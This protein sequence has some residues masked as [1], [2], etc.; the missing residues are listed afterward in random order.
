M[1]HPHSSFY[2]ALERFTR[3][4]IYVN[5]L[6]DVTVPYRTGGI[7][8]I[9]TFDESRLERGE[10]QVQVDPDYPVMIS[11]FKH[12][13]PS[14]PPKLWE[15]V[16]SKF[17]SDKLP[18]F[19]SP[20]RL[21]LRFPLNYL[22][23]LFLPILFPTFLVLVL[24]RFRGDGRNSRRRILMLDE[25]WKL[26]DGE[27][28]E[29]EVPQAKSKRD[30]SKEKQRIERMLK[31]MQK[32]AEVAGEDNVKSEHPAPAPTAITPTSSSHSKSN[33]TLNHLKSNVNGN[34]SA[35]SSAKFDE[36]QELLRSQIQTK[37]PLM[38]SQLEM[39]ENLNRIKTM[40]K[41]RTW[42]E[43]VLNSE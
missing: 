40:R 30:N 36:E 27:T 25:G 29:D 38:D 41:H 33:G 6:R 4:D 17:N 31:R 43:G 32:V 34:G 16:K 11:S 39:C 1:A 10:I 23:I 26:E 21:P 2:K 35:P 42:F 7:D 37:P 28:Q 12:L 8:P 20:S 22:T 9:D 18:W 24:W 19:L 14:P 13:P 3:V 5:G 15:R